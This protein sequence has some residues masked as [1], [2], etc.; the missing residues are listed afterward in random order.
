MARAGAGGLALREGQFGGG[1][2]GHA[3]DP[4]AGERELRTP[5]PSEL[6][7]TGCGPAPPSPAGARGPGEAL[8]A[9]RWEERGGWGLR[10]SLAPLP[11]AGAAAEPAEPYR[12]ALP[13]AGG[14]RGAL[15]GAGGARHGEEEEVG[16]GVWACDLHAGRWEARA[17]APETG[18]APARHAGRWEARAGLPRPG[19]SEARPTAADLHASGFDRDGRRR[20]GRWQERAAFAYDLP[21]RPFGGGLP[22][23]GRRR[24]GAPDEVRMHAGGW[25][26]RARAAHEREH[27]QPSG[28]QCEGLW[29]GRAAYGREAPPPAREFGRAGRWEARAE[30]ASARRGT[31]QEEAARAAARAR[32]EADWEAAQPALGQ[33]P[34]AN[35]PGRELPRDAARRKA[36]EA[37][38]FGRPTL[39]EGG[40][41]GW[42]GRI[43]DHGT[44]H[45]PL[46]AI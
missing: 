31:P 28:G 44:F 21:N 35:L 41:G 5:A 19:G 17:G 15:R 20:Q 26:A 4:P 9:G 14:V 46:R 30:W 24:C 32:G 3:G 7:P 33:R 36:A 23:D 8:H 25:E 18:L 11:P 43:A 38:A 40:T 6:R 1:G 34:A 22:Q 27:P 16:G 12:E 39:P 10:T 13:G 37:A 42:L 45:P 2:R 29:E